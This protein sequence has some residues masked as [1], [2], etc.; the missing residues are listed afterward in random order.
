[1][2]IPQLIEQKK[3][4]I[5]K[6]QT[7]IE[8]LSELA[9]EVTGAGLRPRRPRSRKQAVPRSRRGRKAGRGRNQQRVLAALSVTPTRASEIARSVRLTQQSTTQVLRSLITKGLAV[10]TG[11]GLYKTG[12]ASASTGSR[13][14]RP[15]KES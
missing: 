14:A 2:N 11:R 4:Q 12:S 13:S 5:A 7:Q 1:M 3:A 8:V 6:L 9:G 15:A 10:R